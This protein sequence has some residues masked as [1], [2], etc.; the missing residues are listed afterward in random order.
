MKS[1]KV[2]TLSYDWKNEKPKLELDG[3]L[4]ATAEKRAEF[5]IPVEF[6]VKA[7]DLNGAETMA[8]EYMEEH[9]G[10]EAYT[11]NTTYTEVPADTEQ[12]FF[13]KGGEHDKMV[14]EGHDFFE[15]GEAGY[16]DSDS[17]KE[18]KSVREKGYHWKDGDWKL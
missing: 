14:A 3:P 11:I 7:N 8:H 10:H 12:N 16:T 13:A 9:Y 17:Y 18:W 4:A 1:F 2:N 15:C 6:I 5:G